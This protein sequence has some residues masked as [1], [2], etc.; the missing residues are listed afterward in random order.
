MNFDSPYFIFLGPI[1]CEFPTKAFKFL[2]FL[3]DKYMN[4]K[5]YEDKFI[6]DN[7]TFYYPK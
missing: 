2:N 3:A 1:N 7:I 4:I 5:I 6:S